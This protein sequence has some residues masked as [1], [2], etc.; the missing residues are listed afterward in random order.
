[1][2]RRLKI[3]AILL[4][5]AMAVILVGCKPM[6]YYL[7][8]V[9]KAYGSATESGTG[10]PLES[11]EVFLHPYQYSVLSNGLGDYGIELAEGTWQLDF[12]KSGY[13]TVSKA[14]TV[15][16]ANPRVK[17]DA[18]LSRVTGPEEGWSYVGTWVIPEHNGNGGGPPGKIVLTANTFA[19]YDNDFDATPTTTGSFTLEGSWTGG[20]AH[21]FKGIFT[22]QGFTMYMLMRVGTNNT[23]METEWLPTAYP[24]D[25]DPADNNYDIWTRRQ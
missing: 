13:V 22:G 23:V 7:E 2:N 4:F 16:A 24:P 14:V 1:M 25:I 21:S 3:G 9:Y 19:F 12:V 11:V 17:V 18:V 8:R 5:A 6:N 20:G 15:G 10:A